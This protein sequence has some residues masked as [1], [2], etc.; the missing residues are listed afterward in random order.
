MSDEKANS[1]KRYRLSD[2][3]EPGVWRAYGEDDHGQERYLGR[4]VQEDNAYRAQ[5]TCFTFQRVFG[6]VEEAV[7]ALYRQCMD[8]GYLKKGHTNYLTRVTRS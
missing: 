1:D 4:I 5:S 3:V 8:S 2:A 6:S 7:H